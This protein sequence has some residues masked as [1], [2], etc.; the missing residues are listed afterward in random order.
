MNKPLSFTRYFCPNCGRH[1]SEM[2]LTT[3][4][5]NATEEERRKM[6]HIAHE[7]LLCKCGKKYS[8]F[9]LDKITIINTH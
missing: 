9:E 1:T 5:Y 8:W 2:E 7:I 4:K 6:P 3:E